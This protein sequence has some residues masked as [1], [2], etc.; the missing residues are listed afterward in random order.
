MKVKQVNQYKCDFCGKK[1]YAAGHMKAHEM[2]CTKN[3]NR[4]CRMCAA[5]EQENDLPKLISMLPPPIM[6]DIEGVEDFTL[7]N[8]VDAINA[9]IPAVI[10]EAGG[11]PACV[12]A[13][14]R[15][16]GIPV[17]ATNFD[18]KTEGEKFWK[19]VNGTA[20]ERDARAY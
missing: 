7:L 10:K 16:K 19:E 12:L 8:N 2:H 9:I 1:G 11:C 18:Y 20:Y 15:L 14:I 17:R 3:P 13:A 5:I 4:K 6:S